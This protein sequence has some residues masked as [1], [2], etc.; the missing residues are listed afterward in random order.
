MLS[1]LSVPCSMK[2]NQDSYI[3]ADGQTLDYCVKNTS[4]NY[5][6]ISSPILAVEGKEL[7]IKTSRYTYWSSV[8]EGS[9]R[10][11]LMSG[12]ERT[13]LGNSSK[14]YPDWTKFTGDLHVYP[15]KEVEG[16]CGFYGLVWMHNG[17]TFIADDP[18]QSANDGKV[19][20]CLANASLYLH[21]GSTMAAEQGLRGM[22]VG[23]LEM[24]KGSVLTGYYKSKSAQN[25]YYMIGNGDYNA[26][27]AGRIAP[28]QDNMAMKVG[29]IKEGK[30]TY[31]IT[32]NDNLITGGI[33]I[34]DGK[35]LICND[36]AEAKSKKLNGATGY[37][38]GDNNGVVVRK[39]GTIGG[40][41]SIA[42]PT[43]VFGTMA[44]GDDN[45]GILH[46]ADYV[47]GTNPT[48]T[49]RPTAIL[50][51][52]IRSANYHD[53][54]EVE[55]NV[56]YNNIDENFNTSDKMPRVVIHLTEDA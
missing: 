14:A 20:K 11:N 49:L 42:L 7:T 43:E 47:K 2:A 33:T 34:L 18:I 17:K 12:G 54:I 6:V 8:V 30:G 46:I 13:F 55:G 3:I 22:R 28:W 44:P 32:G 50:N 4:S 48:L 26:T 39:A 31:R 36:A 25:S 5:T 23:K 9:G 27:L 38:S 41:G 15:Y 51:M 19:N 37:K 16:S 40:D 29:L 56:A 10:I 24:E 35:V 53:A 1:L 21:E 45:I 52:K